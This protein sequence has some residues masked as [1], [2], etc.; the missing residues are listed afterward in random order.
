MEDVIVQVSSSFGVSRM[1]MSSL[2]VLSGVINAANLQ[3]FIVLIF[4]F[5]VLSVDIWKE[6]N[7]GALLSEELL[8]RPT[9][10]RMCAVLF[11]A[12]SVLFL[13]LYGPGYLEVDLIYANF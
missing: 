1:L 4:V 11:L 5:V 6:K 10:I 9:A 2:G 12:L 7:R 13:G 8:K 3:W